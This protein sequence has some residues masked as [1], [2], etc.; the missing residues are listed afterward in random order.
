MNR[1]DELVRRTLAFRD[2]VE[3]LSFD[4]SLYVYDP[5]VYAWDAHRLYLEKWCNRQ[6]DILLLG[7]PNWGNIFAAK[8]SAGLRI[9]PIPVTITSETGFVIIL[10]R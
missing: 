2:E 8:V 5:L 1:A 4:A 10:F 7:M 9:P 6:V 3:R